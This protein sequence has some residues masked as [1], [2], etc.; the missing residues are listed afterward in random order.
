[1]DRPTGAAKAALESKATEA[2]GL[3]MTLILEGRR[4]LVHFDA[5]KNNI[6]DNARAAGMP[7]PFACKAGVCATCRAKLGVPARSAWRPITA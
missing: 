4:R 2:A 1:V 7:A 6:L 5:E 3:P